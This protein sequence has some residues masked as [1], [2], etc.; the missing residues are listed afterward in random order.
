MFGMK[1]SIALNDGGGVD[2]GF[3]VTYDTKNFT[4]TCKKSLIYPSMGIDH[5]N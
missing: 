4:I 1:V 5:T 2:M 3:Y